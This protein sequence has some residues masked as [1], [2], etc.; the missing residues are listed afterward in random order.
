MKI[1]KVSFNLEAMSAMTLEQF[2]AI[3]KEESLGISYEEAWSILNPETK[4]ISVA[5]SKKKKG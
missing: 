3:T 5:K 4:P 1:G 2:K